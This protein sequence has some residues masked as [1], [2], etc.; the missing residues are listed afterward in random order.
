MA[1][2]LQLNLTE[3]AYLQLRE[4]AIES[5]ADIYPP[6]N[7]VQ[8]MKKASLPKDIIYK[9]DEVVVTLQATVNNQ[10]DKICQL[11]P[12][13]V[14]EMV[15]IKKENPGAKIVFSYKFGG[16]D[17]HLKNFLTIKTVNYTCVLYFRWIW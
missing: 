14:E 17:Y 2:L 5:G 10:I 8:E 13:M 12:E 3:K 9:D 4:G 16:G 1:L 6:Y 7:K 11:S 15:R